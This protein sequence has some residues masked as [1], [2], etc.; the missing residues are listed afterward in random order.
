MKPITPGTSLR[1][2]HGAGPFIAKVI[3]MTDKTVTLRRRH[4]RGK[5]WVTFYL[6]R[7]FLDSQAC[8]WKVALEKRRGASG[9]V[10]GK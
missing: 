9:P 4:P 3:S 6:P 1:S 10:E 7:W 5:L 8:G 2:N